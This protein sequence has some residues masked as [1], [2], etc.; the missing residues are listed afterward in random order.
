MAL[1]PFKVSDG[2]TIYWDSNTKKIMTEGGKRDSY[3]T[4]NSAEEAQS[5]WNNRLGNKGGS[6]GSSSRSPAQTYAEMIIE[7][8]KKQIEEQKKFLG[9][10][11][12]NNKFA[13]DE[14][15]AKEA[16]SSEYSP[17]YDEMLTD[18]LKD[19]DL[20]RQ[21]VQD[22]QKLSTELYKLDTE[23][24]SRE[25]TRALRRAN[26]GYSS[27]GTFY[28]GARE[29]QIG[30]GTVEYNADRQGGQL[31]QD[32]TQRG[33]DR[34]LQAYDIQQS[35]KERDIGREKDYAIA[36]GVEQRRGEALNQYNSNLIQAY[37]RRFS[38]GDP[39]GYTVA[40]Y[41]RY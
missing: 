26:E 38:P 31:R 4:A 18:F 35:N 2:S 39:A 34:T 8:Q 20:K 28:S 16:S 41:L 33:F 29:G 1:V 12:E 32:A 36:S 10:Y 6:S 25:F 15:L 14:Q 23:A 5:L 9:N 21:T 7:A 3:Y 40:N 19:I 17:Y 27:R 24:S 11:K 37:S 22:D 13:F 30:E